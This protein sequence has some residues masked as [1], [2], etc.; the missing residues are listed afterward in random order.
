MTTVNMFKLAMRDEIPRRCFFKKFFKMVHRT[1]VQGQGKFREI[2]KRI[3]I[4][5]NSFFKKTAG[6][7]YVGGFW[8]EKSRDA[9]GFSI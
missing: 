9:N 8:A 3:N 2:S 1:V 7:L 6:N 5:R 4:R